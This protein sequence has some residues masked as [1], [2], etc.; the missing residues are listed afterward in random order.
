MSPSAFLE[1]ERKATFRHEYVSGTIIS[2]AGASPAH[3]LILS[4][5]ITLSGAFLK[6]RSCN[7]Y[8]S[9]LRVYVP[10]HESY[11]YPDAS[12][13]CGTPDL[14]DEV[15]DIVK[16]RWLFLRY[17]HLLLKTTTLAANFSSICK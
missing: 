17:F 6:G 10:S 9:D 14:S 12:I 4:N 15:K 16:T 13:I 5:L 11:F 3:N 7:I 8:P 2:M 1:W